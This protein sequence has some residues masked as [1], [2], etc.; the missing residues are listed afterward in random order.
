MG[1]RVQCRGEDRIKTYAVLF[2]PYEKQIIVDT[3]DAMDEVPTAYSS[4]EQIHEPSK[5]VSHN[6]TVAT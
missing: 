5:N 4:D 1:A 6:I 2:V 3:S